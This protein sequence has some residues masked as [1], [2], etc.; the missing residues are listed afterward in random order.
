MP[1]E[2]AQ[3]LEGSDALPRARKVADF[4]AGMTDGFA[5]AEHTRLFETTPKL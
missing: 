2:W 4:I 1:E 3:G 5:L